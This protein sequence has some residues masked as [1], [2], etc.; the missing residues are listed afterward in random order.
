[1]IN[2]SSDT[3][4]E[5]DSTI[6]EKCLHGD[7]GAFELLVERYQYRLYTIVCR[8]MGDRD[9]AADVLQNVFIKVFENLHTYNTR[10]KFYSWLYRIAVNESYNFL[11]HRERMTSLI[12]TSH[13]SVG[14]PPEELFQKYDTTKSIENALLGL[15]TEHRIIIVL[16]H[17]GE[18]SYR[19]I[20]EIL[21]I[22]KKT[23]KSRLFSARQEL[24]NA[25]LKRGDTS[26]R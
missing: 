13:I 10:Y 1:M 16:K 4:D 8:I 2:N 24:K 5:S 11:H 21:E 3:K 23:V 12:A 18:L 25:L 26:V 19:E 17:F 22:P 15:K 7:T 20:A 6:I 14:E 9:D